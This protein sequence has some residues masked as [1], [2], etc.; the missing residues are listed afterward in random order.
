MVEKSRGMV[1]GPFPELKDVLDSLGEGVV[2]LNKDYTIAFINDFS[3]RLVNMRHEEVL[4]RHCYEVFHQHT[5]VCLDCPAKTVFETGAATSLTYSGT[6]N[7]GRTVW[8]E[9]NAYPIF[10]C[11]GAVEKVIETVKDITERKSLE[12]RLRRSEEKY[13]TLVETMNDGLGVIDRERKL[14][15][16]NRKFAQML[17][18]SEEELLGRDVITLFNEENRE[19]LLE[20]LKKR[21]RGEASKYNIEFTTKAGELL[22][23]IISATPLLDEKGAHVGSF[24]VITDVKS[25]KK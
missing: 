17:G 10:N 1:K 2:V 19:K 18:Y 7:G 4:G 16:C 14:T 24:A 22:P 15:F 8:V 23:V 21:A 9:L 11:E 5:G 25:E 13:R 6:A 3:L 12:E 20:E